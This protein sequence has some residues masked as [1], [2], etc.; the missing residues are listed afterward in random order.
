MK[1]EL[2]LIWEDQ[3]YL[4]DFFYAEPITSY[5]D[6]M[7]PK[8]SKSEPKKAFELLDV[9]GDEINIIAL[10]M[11]R[12]AK[13]LKPYLIDIT[14]DVFGELGHV[15][16]TRGTKLVWIDSKIAQKIQERLNSIRTI[17]KEVDDFTK[18][19]YRKIAEYEERI[20]KILDTGHD[21]LL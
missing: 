11:E 9:N 21:L 18:L 3:S 15:D 4:S 16:K 10:T 6:N 20:K 17:E 19:S 13:G 2:R 1:E 8:P 12:M 7:K 5:L 14:E